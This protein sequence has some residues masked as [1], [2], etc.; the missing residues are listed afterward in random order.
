MSKYCRAWIVTVEF[1]NSVLQKET[2]APAYRSSKLR[3]RFRYQKNGEHL[4]VLGVT[5]FSTAQMEQTRTRS[6][7]MLK[8]T[9]KCSSVVTVLTK[10]L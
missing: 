1:V 5:E 6:S 9:K 10:W 2:I 3:P 4:L 8:E 7:V